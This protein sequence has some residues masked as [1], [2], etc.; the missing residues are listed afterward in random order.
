TVNVHVSN[1]RKKIKEEDPGEE[2]IQT[3]YGIGFKLP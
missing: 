3:V 2:Y 1:I